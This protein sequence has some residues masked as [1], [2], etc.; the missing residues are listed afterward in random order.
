[1]D[2]K[3]NRIL[4]TNVP[5]K[6]EIR[7]T[8]FDENEVRSVIRKATKGRRHIIAARMTGILR[9]DITSKDVR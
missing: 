2:N 7:G 9:R 1:M 8:P 5:T 4:V 6:Q 3:S